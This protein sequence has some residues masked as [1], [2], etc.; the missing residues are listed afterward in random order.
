MRPRA[1][2][3]VTCTGVQPER[4]PTEPE[5]SSADKKAWVMNGLHRSPSASSNE[6]PG[7]LAQA[8]H[9]AASMAAIDWT[10]RAVKVVEDM[11]SS[12]PVWGQ[13]AS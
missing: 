2:S 10:T 7:G 1:S 12:G 8:S 3:T 5:A 9:A 11:G 6:R 13:G 4:A